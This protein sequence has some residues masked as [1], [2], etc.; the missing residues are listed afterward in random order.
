MS[1]FLTSDTHFGHRNIIGYCNQPFTDVT[2]MDAALVDRWN[3]LVRPTDEIWLL[4]DVAMGQ[5]GQTLQ[6]V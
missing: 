5:L 6:I 3:D 1:L 2:E 4:G